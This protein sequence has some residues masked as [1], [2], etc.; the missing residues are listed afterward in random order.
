MKL[1]LAALVLLLAGCASSEPTVAPPV[2]DV[3]PTTWLGM[4]PGDARAFDG[5]GGELVLIAVDET[6]TIG[7]VN[8]SATT[9]KH[10]DD[11]TTDYWLEDD[12]GTLWWY[13]RR[14][15]WRAGRNGEKPREVEIVDGRAQFGDRA[16]TVS[17]DDGPVQLETPDGVYTM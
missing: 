10:G 11:Y 7:D 2:D 3:A 8:A 12:D 4:N 14:G 9:W 6:Y 1:F 17:E 16:I 15:S 5:P 13:G